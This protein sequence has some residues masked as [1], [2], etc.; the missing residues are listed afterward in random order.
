MKRKLMEYPAVVWNKRLWS[1]QAQQGFSALKKTK[2]VILGACL[3]RKAVVLAGVVDSVGFQG[4]V[5]AV[6]VAP[7][8]VIVT[9]VLNGRSTEFARGVAA[10]AVPPLMIEIVVLADENPALAKDSVGSHLSWQER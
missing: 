10:T 1:K 7:V 2:K 5:S 6:A 9:A 4:G 3:D 8:V